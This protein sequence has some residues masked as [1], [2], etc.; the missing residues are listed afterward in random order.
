MP[1]IQMLTAITHFNCTALEITWPAVVPEALESSSTGD[2]TIHVGS[3]GEQ[4]LASFLES[5]GNQSQLNGAEAGGC[6][7]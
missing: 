4:L 3:S 5:A 7:D 1:W 6:K 2:T